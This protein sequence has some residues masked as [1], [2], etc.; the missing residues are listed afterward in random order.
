MPSAFPNSLSSVRAMMQSYD[1]DAGLEIGILLI[2]HE[3]HAA[4]GEVAA[5][6][7]FREIEQ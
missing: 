4:F 2:A 6:F 3:C 1:G 5:L 7:L